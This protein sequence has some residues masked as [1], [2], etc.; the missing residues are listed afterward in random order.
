MQEPVRTLYLQALYRRH[1][2]EII[3]RRQFTLAYLSSIPIRVKP[4]DGE[5][6]I[7]YLHIL[8]RVNDYNE[9]GLTYVEC[10][11]PWDDKPVILEVLL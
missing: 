3:E 4:E 2:Y 8:F 10:V 6:P 9:Y 11:H 1:R 5:G 7:P